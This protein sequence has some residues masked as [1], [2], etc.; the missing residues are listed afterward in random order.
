MVVGVEQGN[1]GVKHKLESPGIRGCSG[2]EENQGN[3]T[4]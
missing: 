1:G 2:R 4:K 3:G